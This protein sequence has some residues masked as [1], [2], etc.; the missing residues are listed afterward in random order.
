[1]ITALNNMNKDSKKI[2][3]VVTTV[4]QH[5]IQYIF[6]LW[7]NTIHV[8]NTLHSRTSQ[9]AGLFKSRGQDCTCPATICLLDNFEVRLKLS[10]ESRN[11][12][13]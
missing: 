13:S 12:P 8:R 10:A 1:M 2:I 9:N 7:L 5:I 11:L 3:Q 4:I 6:I